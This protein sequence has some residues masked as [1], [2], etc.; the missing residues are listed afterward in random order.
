MAGSLREI[1]QA[2]TQ[3]HDSTSTMRVAL[4]E[5]TTSFTQIHSNENE[6]LT[7]T[8]EAKHSASTALEAQVGC[9]LDSLR[10]GPI[11]EEFHY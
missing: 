1:E 10:S 3:Q 11:Y 7:A 6:S 4:E 2:I 9:G 5:L 8:S